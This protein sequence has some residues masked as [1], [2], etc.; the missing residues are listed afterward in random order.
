MNKKP[1]QIASDLA[2]VVRGDVYADILHR[3]A[4]STDASIYRIVP[5]CIVAP[6]DAGD[7]VAVVGY[8]AAEAI[9]VVARG[10]GSG[11]AGE[12]LSGGL[13]INMTRYMNKIIGTEDDGQKIICEPGVVLDDLNKYLAEFG[14]KIWTDPS[15]ANRAV[16][17]GALPITPPARMRSSTAIWVT[18]S[19]RLKRFWRTAALLSSKMMLTRN[20]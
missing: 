5:Q 3:A 15:S 7:V 18:T 17:G 14:R 13:V 2:G 6:R 9:T 12:S 11:L 4:Y 8:A 10:A 19:K 16:I 1:E 20:R